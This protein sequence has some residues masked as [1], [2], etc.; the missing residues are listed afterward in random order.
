MGACV[1]ICVSIRRAMEEEVFS[2]HLRLESSC[3]N[4]LNETPTNMIK[5]KP[6]D[7]FVSKR[8][9]EDLRE[10]KTVDGVTSIMLG[11]AMKIGQVYPYTLELDFPVRLKIGLPV[12]K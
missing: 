1:S 2:R 3:Q 12:K 7:S 8:S 11:E 6:W 10:V 5:L 4:S 9:F